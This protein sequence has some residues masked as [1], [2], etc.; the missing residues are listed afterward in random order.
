MR[1]FTVLRIYRAFKGY[2]LKE[3]AEEIGVSARE[4]SAIERGK[5]MAD[6]AS[7][8]CVVRWLLT[9]E[10]PATAKGS[11]DGRRAKGTSQPTLISDT[12]KD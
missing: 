9:D 3:L 7:L 6:G 10:Q 5:K 1:L 12:A 11:S 8:A 2:E 4:L